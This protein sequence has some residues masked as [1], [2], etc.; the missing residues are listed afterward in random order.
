MH[1]KCF[2]YLDSH[3]NWSFTELRRHHRS[4]VLA[5]RYA[6]EVQLNSV[7]A[8][9]SPAS[10]FQSDSTVWR[11][12]LS[13]Q[14]G[15][16]LI[17]PRLC[18]IDWWSDEIEG[19]LKCLPLSFELQVLSDLGWFMCEDVFK[20]L[21]L[22]SE[23]LH[24]TLVVL[25]VVVNGADHVLHATEDRLRTDSTCLSLTSSPLSL[26]LRLLWAAIELLFYPVKPNY[27]SAILFCFPL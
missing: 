11:S 16:S 7:T 6:S 20:L 17:H 3:L 12:L 4:R 1:N 14:Q 5:R 21:F 19:W 24:F 23:H 13:G 9:S 15:S 18:T 2:I 10:G 25:N 27:C 8:G 26:V 22:L